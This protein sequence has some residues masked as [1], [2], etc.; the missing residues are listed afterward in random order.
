MGKYIAFGQFDKKYFLYII[1]IGLFS[2]IKEIYG[3]FNK[4]RY[5]NMLMSIF[6]LNFFLSLFIIPDKIINKNILSKGK[7]TSNL[8]Y[9]LKFKDFIFIIINSLLLLLYQILENIKDYSKIDFNFAKKKIS[10]NFRIIILFIISILMFKATYYKHQY[11][12]FSYII[13]FISIQ[14]IF[15]LFFFQFDFVIFCL[16]LI[17]DISIS[18]YFGLSKKFMEKYYF[19]PYKICYLSGIINGIISLIIYFIISHIPCEKNN[20][21]II[22]NEK[23]YFDNIYSFISTLNLNK[24]L[25]F[26]EKIFQAFTSFLINLVIQNYTISHIF[27]CNLEFFG[28]KLGIEYKPLYIIFSI[29]FGIF[30]LLMS[31]VFLEFIELK[32]CELNKN[33][34]KNINKRVIEEENSDIS[35]NKEVIA[36]INNDYIVH[37]GQEEKDELDLELKNLNQ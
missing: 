2:I 30:E 9:K 32:F 1:L 34:K 19:S 37:L 17:M 6:I 11:F 36:E 10:Y 5:N 7:N 24:I 33:L 21:N 26:L 27:I 16:N 25:L 18:I 29:C 12:S 14:F 4:E 15:D 3:Y 35:E 20:C 23:K 31:L 22:Y 13:L 28:L 8:N